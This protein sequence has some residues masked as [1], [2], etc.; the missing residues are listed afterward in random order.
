[1]LSIC[2]SFTL[3]S[4]QRNI[5]TIKGMCYFINFLK[6]ENCWIFCCPVTAQ[7][8]PQYSVVLL[9]HSTLLNILLP[10]Y[11][12]VHSS[13][14]CCPVTA[15]HTPEYSGVLLQ[16]STLLNILCPVTA[17]HNPEYSVVL[18]QHSTLLNILLPSYSTAHSSIFCCPFTAQY[19]PQYSVILLQHSTLP[20]A[21]C[22]STACCQKPSNT[23]R[24]R[25]PRHTLGAGRLQYG[26][27]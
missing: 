17:Q 19:T 21:I 13:M 7:H 14:F 16:H 6:L 4:Y 23:W 3:T 2:C 8:T 26:S 22:R 15:Q 10:C 27:S 25:A 18:L 1:V 12:T 11:S 24:M 20:F 9:Q 5:H